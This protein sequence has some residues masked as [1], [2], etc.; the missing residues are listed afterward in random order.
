VYNRQFEFIWVLSPKLRVNFL[1]VINGIFEAPQKVVAAPA[2]FAGSIPYCTVRNYKICT[3]K[4]IQT[5]PLLNKNFLS[6]GNMPAGKTYMRIQIMSFLPKSKSHIA[7]ALAPLKCCSELVR[8]RL[9]H[10]GLSY[11]VQYNQCCG[12]GTA[13]SSIIALPRDGAAIK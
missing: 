6:C 4:S 12:S 5:H 13:R 8:H 3:T 7:T 1:F 10:I 11:T 9:R 2:L